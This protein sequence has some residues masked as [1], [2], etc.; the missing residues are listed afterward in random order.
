MKYRPVFR[1]DGPPVLE[2]QRAQMTNPSG[3]SYTSHRLEVQDGAAGAVVIAIANGRILLVLSERPAAGELMWEL[4]RGF[5]EATD[6]DA[7]DPAA[8]IAGAERELLE[9]T[10]LVSLSSE[11]IGTYITDSSIYPSKIGVVRCDVDLA[12]RPGAWDGEIEE[13]RWVE[14]GTLPELVSNGTIHDAHSLAALACWKF[15]QR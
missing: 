3:L 15:Q 6:G 13:V 5:G 14:L 1:W 4:P 11:L 7:N 8:M 2:L 9:E 12:A 10:G